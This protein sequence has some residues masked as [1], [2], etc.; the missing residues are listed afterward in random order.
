MAEKIIQR[1]DGINKHIDYIQK[2]LNGISFDVF[3]NKRLLP[4][5][6]CFS[7]A[8]VGE[9]MN[10]LEELL[11]ERFPDL[12]WKQA[13]KMRNIIVHDY[14]GVDYETVYI[15]ST[16]DLPILK[17]QLLEVKDDIEKIN[18]KSICTERLMLRPWCDYDADELFELAKEPEIGY[19]CGWEKHKHIRDSFFALHNFLEVPETYAILL[20]ENHKLI[21]SISLKFETNL[22]KNKNECELGFWVGK[23]FWNNGYTTEA[24]KKIIDHAF[25][26]LNISA[27][28]C[29]Y[30]KGNEKSKRVQEKLGFKYQYT[31]DNITVYPLNESRTL[32]VSVLKK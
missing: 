5:A 19:W 18:E 9:R 28:W 17:K 20:K 8:Q 6:I 29:G 13:R 3:K 16:Q 15:T 7:L 21:G 11:C 26:D 31:C 23:P 4:E 32:F 10:K 30:Y 2:E 12:P 24:A 25:D 1:I 14:D 22:A 27:I